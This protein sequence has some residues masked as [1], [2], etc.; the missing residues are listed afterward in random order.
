MFS[1]VTVNNLSEELKK[2][3]R[4]NEEQKE[5]ILEYERQTDHKGRNF[6]RN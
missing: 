4:T 1:D 2:I 5:K 3:Q 6:F